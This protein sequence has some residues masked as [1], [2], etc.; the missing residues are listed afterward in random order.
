MSVKDLED[1][2]SKL[3]EQLS[4]K[5]EAWST[6][7]FISEHFKGC[8]RQDLVFEFKKLFQKYESELES[9]EESYEGRK[10]ELMNLYREE[11]KAGLNPQEIQSDL[12]KLSSRKTYGYDLELLEREASSRGIDPS[13]FYVISRKFEPKMVP[14]SLKETL[15]AAKY[16]KSV[17]A[18]VKEKSGD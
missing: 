5:K 3:K 10:E 8:D 14:D 18:V 1:E 16:V 7:S 2:L 17:S 12:F 4:L 9:L 13:E 11:V 6:A 15:K